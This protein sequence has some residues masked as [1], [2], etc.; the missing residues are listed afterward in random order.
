MFRGDGLLARTVYAE[1]A[2]IKDMSFETALKLVIVTIKVNMM[3]YKITEQC[4]VVSAVTTKVDELN[5]LLQ[6][7]PKPHPFIKGAREGLLAWGSGLYSLGFGH[8]LYAWSL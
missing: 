8:G 7:V 5:L 1:A 3:P 6:A 4:F 2:A